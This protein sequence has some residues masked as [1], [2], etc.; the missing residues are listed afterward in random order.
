[1]I[2]A[3]WR[4]V[5]WPIRAFFRLGPVKGAMALLATL[6]AVLLLWNLVIAPQLIKVMLAHMPRPVMPVTVAEAK[7]ITWVP[8]LEAVG[9]AKAFNGADLAAEA[10]GVITAIDVKPQDKVTQGQRL[11]QIDDAVEE[12]DLLAMR[13]NVKLQESALGRVAQLTSKGVNAQSQLDDARNR[14]DVA[15]SQQARIEAVIAQKS[16]KALFDGTAGI[17]RVNV[18]QYVTKGTVLITLQ[19][20]DRVYVDF[21]IPE[22]SVSQVTLGQTVRLGTTKD[23]LD[24]EGHIIGIDP[25]VDPD[26]RLIAVRA[27]IDNANG[28]I[29]PGQFLQLRIDLPSEARVLALPMTAVVPSLYGDYVYLAVPPEGDKDAASD[30]RVVRQT[31]VTVGRRSGKLVEIKD[32][33]APG[34][35]VVATGQNAVQS[36]AKVKIVEH[37]D[38]AKLADGGAIQ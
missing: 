37:V 20:L 19:D 25:K 13:A 32:G 23:A 22:Q 2:K 24:Y 36:G 1:M 29:L 8:G 6:C 35:L 27:E 10:D 34:Q 9:T 28:R 7:T 15:K 21:T 5:T 14:L 3:L 17:P 4:F 33:L 16:T 12:A 18:G 38:P 30:I 26:T 11:I 31:I